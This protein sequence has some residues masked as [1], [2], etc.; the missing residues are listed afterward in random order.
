MNTTRL[1]TNLL[2]R[3]GLKIRLNLSSSSSSCHHHQQSIL[4]IMLGFAIWIL[5]LYFYLSWAKPSDR[6]Y[7]IRSTPATFIHVPFGQ[8]LLLG[9][10]STCIEKIRLTNVVAFLSWTCPKTHRRASLNL[11]LIV[12]TLKCSQ[13]HPISGSIFPNLPHMRLNILIFA[14]LILCMH[15]FLIG[16]HSSS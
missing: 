16:Q 4:P 1:L 14:T 2:I 11:L 13:M 10:P 5:F 12:A 15:W 8:P 7:F 6:L 3:H 9:R